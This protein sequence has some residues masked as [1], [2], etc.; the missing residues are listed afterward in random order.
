MKLLFCKGND[1]ESKFIKFV[2]KSEYTHVG[3]YFTESPFLEPMVYE[4][5]DTYGVHSIPASSYASFNGE[6]WLA[7][8]SPQPDISQLLKSINWSLKAPYSWA[9]AAVI[10]IR[11]FTKIRIPY[12]VMR[13]QY[14]CSEFVAT[15]LDECGLKIV[16]W[17]ELVSVDE[18]SKS[19]FITKWTRLY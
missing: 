5:V 13:T 11:I 2:T 3:L 15:K 19:P 17:P 14:I 10:S 9:E 4:A 8:I 6:V 12:H 16:P 18:L 1:L 7:D